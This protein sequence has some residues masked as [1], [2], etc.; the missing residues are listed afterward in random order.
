MEHPLPQLRR[1]GA[2]V[3]AADV[4]VAFLRR[5]QRGAAFGTRCGHDEFAFGAIAQFD[6][7]GQHLGNHIAGLAQHHGVTDQHTLAFDLGR[8]VQGGQTDGG[9]GHLDRFHVGE[10]GDPS[11]APDIDADIEEFGGDLFGRV[12]IG[13][14]PPRGPRGRAE[15]ALQ[16][17]I[18]DFDDQAVYLVFDIVA[19]F[20]PVGDAFGHRLDALDLGGVG[21]HRQPPGAQRPVRVVQRA[22]RE[23]LGLADSMADHPQLAPRGHGGILLPQRASGAVARVGE[24][25]LP[26][27]HQ[28]G[29]EFLEIGQPEEHLPAHLEHGGYREFVGAGEP[30]G[31]VLDGAGI[32]GDILAAAAVTA[33]GAADQN[34]LTVDQGQRDTVDLELAQI[35]D[36]G[37]DFG[38]HPRCPCSQLIGVECVVQRQHSLQMVSRGEV[39]GETG[40]ADQLGR[41]VRG[42]QFREGVLQRLQF[43]QQGVE[44]GVRND[45]CVLDV[46][47]ELMAAHFFG[48]FLP[49][50]T[51]LCIR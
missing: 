47:A 30:F 20:A 17:H 19:V 33:G 5:G 42:A 27:G 29:V 24:R 12:L 34:A 46:V 2:V 10:W 44:L 15:T 40:A 38:T 41:R 26:L 7:R 16:G 9:S 36:I 21:G 18:V 13:D 50:L 1:T 43:T 22:R 35:V 49:A 3:R 31:N 37:A 48:E 23:P 4:G 45:R 39:G 25:R 14:R 8:V 11:G 51:Y 28:T 32:V 6:D